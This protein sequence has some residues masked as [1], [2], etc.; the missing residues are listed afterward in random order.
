[1]ADL[2]SGDTKY[3]VREATQPRTTI[4]LLVSSKLTSSVTTTTAIDTRRY[5]DAVLYSNISQVSGDGAK[6]TYQ[7][8]GS[9]YNDGNWANMAVF[10][11]VSGATGIFAQ[12]LT[13][14]AYLANWTRFTI[15]S[16][17]SAGGGI[18][19]Q[20]DVNYIR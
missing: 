5:K 14:S 19:A 3:S 10:T 15:S 7:L 9:I 2:T 13:T 16:A 1:M 20:A 12:K 17:T 4:Q 18:W 8:D 11:T 6:L